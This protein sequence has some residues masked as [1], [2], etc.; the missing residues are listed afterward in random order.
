LLFASLALAACPDTVNN[1]GYV[2]AGAGGSGS[3]ADWTNAYTA[4]PASL[5]RGCTYYIAAGTYA[6]HTFGDADSGTTTISI[7]AATSAS[8][9]TSTGWSSGYI[10]QAVFNAPVIFNTDY[11]TFSGVYRSTAAG[12]PM[13]DWVLESGYGFKIN[14]QVVQQGESLAGG[15]GYNGNTCGSLSACNAEGMFV[16]DITIA[17]V[18]VNGAHTKTDAEDIDNG[19][20]F[21]GG[22]YNLDFSHLYVHDA[23]VPYYVRGNHDGQ[24]G[25]GYWFGSGNNVTVEYDYVQN[26]YSSPTYHSEGCSCSEGLTNFVWRYNVTDQIGG[27]GSNGATAHI[28]TASGCLTAACNGTNGPWYIYRNIFTCTT[29][30]SNQNCAVGDG[31]FAAWATNFST[32]NIYFLNNT[33]ASIGPYSLNGGFGIG[34]GYTGSNASSFGTLVTENNL[35]YNNDP[36]DIIPTG[37]TS[38]SGST[39]VGSTWSYNSYFSTPIG[40]SSD[41]D[42]N[43]QVSSSNP[44]SGSTCCFLA[45]DTTA[46]LNTSGVVTGNSTDMMGVL[47]GAN[48]IWDRGALQITGTSGGAT[49]TLR[50]A[51][52]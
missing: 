18:D 9:G 35:W 8:H 20:D 30:L 12:N 47:A 42:A 27:T 37:T 34:L 52:R 6:A 36:M 32:N 38:Y 5:V 50:G 15:S 44:F 19:V 4:L 28:G 14:N 29:T 31:A 21:E 10:G 1:A 46:G 48:G 13:I 39:M 45:A 33:I 22:S 16:H 26:D 23:A 2:R 43:K 40:A 49:I 3:G 11:Y 25:G 41:S 17:Y 7:L 51:F 24:A